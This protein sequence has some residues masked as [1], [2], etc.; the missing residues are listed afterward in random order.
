[1]K[2]R[3]G[4]FVLVF[5][6]LFGNLS[7]V[8]PA[9]AI[10]GKDA[11]VFKVPTVAQGVVKRRKRADDFATPTFGQNGYLGFIKP[12]KLKGYGK[13]LDV[14]SPVAIPKE[15]LI[16]NDI[17]SFKDW[18]VQFEKNKDL[19]STVVNSFV[20]GVPLFVYLQRHCNIEMARSL[21]G[22]ISEVSIL[23]QYR[24]AQ[25]FLGL[26]D[27]ELLFM[28]VELKSICI[29]SRIIEESANRWSCIMS[30]DNLR[31]SVLSYALLNNDFEMVKLL[32]NSL[33]K[34]EYKYSLLFYT[35]V[36]GVPA[37]PYLEQNKSEQASLI[38]SFVKNKIQLPEELQMMQCNVAMAQ[39]RKNIDK[40][41]CSA[42]SQS[43]LNLVFLIMYRVPMEKRMDY[44]TK[45]YFDGNRSVLDIVI[46]QRISAV[47]NM[48]M[49]IVG[50]KNRSE[51]IRAINEITIDRYGLSLR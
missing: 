34:D 39:K 29:A 51:M 40:L 46:E 14:Y 27:A 25:S 33:E 21:A 50:E 5:F 44:L 7:Y 32:I 15:I 9:K 13:T 49:H 26:S 37:I 11:T 22:Y 8:F 2:N 18:T 10:K 36:D 24:K 43:N 3:N 12:I 47:L 48:F 41:F 1:V 30:F 23:N 6:L 45:K 38:L 31:N 20:N 42:I 17:R 16:N 19:E 35:C 4:L 28:A